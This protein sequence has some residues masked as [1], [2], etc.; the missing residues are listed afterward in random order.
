MPATNPTQVLPAF[1][2]SALLSQSPPN[3]AC[4]LIHAPPKGKDFKQSTNIA[5]T[6]TV[7]IYA[8]FL[9]KLIEHLLLQVILF[10]YTDQISLVGPEMSTKKKIS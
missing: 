6:V 7:M 5:I 2:I 1:D 8:L 10:R 4:Q 9:I 3:I